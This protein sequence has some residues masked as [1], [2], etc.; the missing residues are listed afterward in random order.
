MQHPH[1]EKLCFGRKKGNSAVGCF[2]V[3]SMSWQYSLIH[4]LQANLTSI[5]PEAGTDFLKGISL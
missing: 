3:C 1:E 5:S 4:V 2:D